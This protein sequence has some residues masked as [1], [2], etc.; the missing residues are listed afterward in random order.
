MER[1]ETTKHFEVRVYYEDVDAGGICYHSKYLNFCE[2]ARS[3]IF[4]S[5]GSSPIQDDRHFVVKRIA[6]NFLG[7]ARLGDTLKIENSIVDLSRASLTMSQR[8]FDRNGNA[9]FEMEVSLVCLEGEKICR[10]PESYLELF[11]SLREE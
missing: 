9:I 1:N 10:I 7:P 11:S 2:R 3:E 8:I 6:A 5:Q 4:F